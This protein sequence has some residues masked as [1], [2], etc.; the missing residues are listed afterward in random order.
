MPKRQR[1][2]KR[3]KLRHLPGGEIREFSGAIAS[4]LIERDD[5][6]DELLADRRT[7]EIEPEGTGEQVE[8]TEQTD[9]PA[10]KE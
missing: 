3:T 5:W 1:F 6:T 4:R 8:Q 2:T 9:P 7:V 10:D